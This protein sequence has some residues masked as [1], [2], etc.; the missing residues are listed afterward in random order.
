MFLLLV[1]QPFFDQLWIQFPFCSPPPILRFTSEIGS[2]LLKIIF[3]TCQVSSSS[4]F[5]LISSPPPS[6][7]GHPTVYAEICAFSFRFLNVFTSLNPAIPQ[8]LKELP[9]FSVCFFFSSCSLFSSNFGHN[10]HSVVLY[11]FSALSLILVPIF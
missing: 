2:D 6:T 4:L 5:P 11:R 1:V 3:H 10:S 7:S 8:F 9:T